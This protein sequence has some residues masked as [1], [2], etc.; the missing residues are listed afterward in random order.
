MERRKIPSVGGL[1][2]I[3]TGCLSRSLK[4]HLIRAL[5]VATHRH[6]EN[7]VD[8]VVDSGCKCSIE[9]II[10]RNAPRLSSIIY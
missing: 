4:F 5:E 10:Y 1:G 6:V 2:S 3:E 9:A 7:V 8:K